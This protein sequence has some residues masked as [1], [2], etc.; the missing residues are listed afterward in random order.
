MCG[1]RYWPSVKLFLSNVSRVGIRQNCMVYSLHFGGKMLGFDSPTRILQRC[2]YIFICLFFC[3]HSS[4]EMF[5]WIHAA[6]FPVSGSVEH[7]LCVELSWWFRNLLCFVKGFIAFTSLEKY[8]ILQFVVKPAIVI[9]LLA[10]VMAVVACYVLI[11]M[12]NMGLMWELLY[13]IC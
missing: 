12:F 7:L 13:L 3:H 11:F 2:M 4:A 6:G 9:S 1:Q 10:N 8:M 5:I